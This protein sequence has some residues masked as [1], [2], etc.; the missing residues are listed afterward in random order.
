MATILEPQ[1]IGEDP[2]RV[3]RI[4]SEFVDGFDTMSRVESGVSIF[5]SA[6][7]PE[8]DP[9]YRKAR[10]LAGMLAK[11]KY[12]V[13]TGGGPGIMAAANQGAIEAG[14]TSVGLNITLPIEQFPNRYQDIT[15]DFRYFFVRLVMF[16]K[17]SCAF[18]CF[19]GGFGTLHEF[20]NSMTLIQTGKAHRFPVVLIGRSFWSGLEEW[21]DK[22][23]LH[24]SYQK[25]SPE[26]MDQFVITDSL[27]EAVDVICQANTPVTHTPN[28]Q[29]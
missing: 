27:H 26:D 24:K 18:V 28:I 1:F 19:P 21:I 5:G 7:T 6:R 20:F 17:Y 3:F 13:I 25:I 9:Y 8:D 23:M 14:G 16:V 29:P 11:K 10:K 22:I 12:T 2:W 15:L 4:L